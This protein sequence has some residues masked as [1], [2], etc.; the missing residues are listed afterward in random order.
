ML[1]P[2]CRLC[3]LCPLCPPRY[4]YCALTEQKAVVL[5]VDVIN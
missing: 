2:L 1:H 5:E 4:V 3:R